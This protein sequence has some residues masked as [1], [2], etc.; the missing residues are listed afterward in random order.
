[1]KKIATA[2]IAVVLVLTMVG[3]GTFSYNIKSYVDIGDYTDA[4]VVYMSEKTITKNVEDAVKNLIENYKET[5]DLTEGTV[6]KDDTVYIY[7]EGTLVVFDGK[8]SM[9]VG[10]SG[11]VGFDDALKNATFTDGKAEFELTLDKDFTMP[12]FVT[13]AKKEEEKKDEDKTSTSGNSK[14]EKSEPQAVNPLFEEN[15]PV[16]LADD[17]KSGTSTSKEEEKSYFAEKKVKFVVTVEGK[18]GKVSDGEAL[19]MNL[20]WTLPGFEGGTYNAK[21]EEDAKKE[22]EKDKKD[23]TSASASEEEEKE[24]ERKGYKLTIGSKSFIDGFEDGLIGV[25]VAKDTKKTLNL[26]FPN[27]Y[28]NNAA[29][30]GM[31]V[32][33]EVT[34]VSVTRDYERDLKN[35]EQFADL[36]KDYEKANGEGTFDYANEQE[37]RDDCRKNAKENAALTALLNASKMKKWPLADYEN[38]LSNTRNQIWSYYYMMSL[39]GQFTRFSSEDELASNLKMTRTEYEQYL[40]DMAGASLKQDLVL[41]QVAKDQGLTDISD[42]DYEEYCKEHALEHGYTDSND[43]TKPDVKGFVESMGGKKAVKKSMAIERAAEKLGEMVA[44]KE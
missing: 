25:S 21:T 11:I 28:K 32:D 38:Y 36:K 29:L 7:Y 31:A 14:E 39:Y 16:A 35:A 43:K 24:E 8:W 4:N 40:A 41:Y 20:R 15:E 26:K 1:M 19:E 2:L 30:S 9:K 33:F 5:K 27:P 37:F 12:S 17:E 6:A 34:I 42:K 18:N 3:C 23:G 10:Q 13:D 44:V 22:E